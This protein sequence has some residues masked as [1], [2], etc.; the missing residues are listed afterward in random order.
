MKSLERAEGFVTST[1][2]WQGYGCMRVNEADIERR[3]M[4][5]SYGY[6]FL[7]INCW[8]WRGCFPDYKGSRESWRGN[9]GYT[10]TEF[11]R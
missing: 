9:Y 2:L 10:R 7:K 8:L 5:E 11:R 1:Q 6:R 4:F 3:L